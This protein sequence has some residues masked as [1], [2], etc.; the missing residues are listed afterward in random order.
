MS[1]PETAVLLSPF[2][3]LFYVQSRSS[4]SGK[5]AGIV[6]CVLWVLGIALAFVVKPGS[7][8]IPVP[9]TLLLLGFLPLLFYWRF[10][11]TWLI[12]AGFNLGIG[13][14]LM[15]VEFLPDNLFP[16]DLVIA[17]HHLAAYHKPLAWLL[18]S[19]SAG[20]YGTVRMVRNISAWMKRRAKPNQSPEG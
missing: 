19:F 14:L 2:P 10:S 5:I 17:K 18:I 9:D 1:V 13:M 12:F 15:A 3:L 20:V 8:F 16:S 7:M 11:W 4:A 6:S